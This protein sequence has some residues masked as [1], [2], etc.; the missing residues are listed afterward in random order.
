[1]ASECVFAVV[2][3]NSMKKAPVL[4]LF[5]GKY[6]IFL[7]LTSNVSC[8]L[9][10]SLDVTSSKMLPFEQYSWWQWNGQ[11]S[12]WISWNWISFG[13]K[14]GCQSWIDSYGQT[15]D[16]LCRLVFSHFK[17]KGV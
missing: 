7:T 8:I 2:L 6:V 4:L 11:P 9:V 16:I 15:D 10:G 3:S 13:W 1:M 14:K 12:W 5:P 17:G